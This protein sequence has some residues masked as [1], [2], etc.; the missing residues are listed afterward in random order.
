[1]ALVAD[2]SILEGPEFGEDAVHITFAPETYEA[3][4]GK[5]IPGAETRTNI[6]LA[7]WPTSNE[8]LMRLV[9]HEGTRVVN[10]RTFALRHAIRLAQGGADADMIEH[11][12]RKYRIVEI[13]DWTP[14]G[15]SEAIGIEPESSR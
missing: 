8:D 5:P 15:F 7:S 3:K 10:S 2:G 1:M 11:G 12:G 14:H 4:T 13:R 6:K 9:E